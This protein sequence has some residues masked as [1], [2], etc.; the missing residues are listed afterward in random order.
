MEVYENY[1]TYNVS[2]HFNKCFRFK[3]WEQIATATTDLIE[4]VGHRWWNTLYYSAVYP[5]AYPFL[6]CCKERV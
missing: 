6:Q 4:L 5:S 1:I 3:K 2:C